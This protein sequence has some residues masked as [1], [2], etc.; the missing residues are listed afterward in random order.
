MFRLIVINNHS[1]NN[2]LSEGACISDIG[3]NCRHACSI[4]HR[5]FARMHLLNEPGMPPRMR[6]RSGFTLGTEFMSD[7]TAD[8][9]TE[10]AAPLK[11]GA[12]SFGSF[13]PKNYV[14]AVF[15]TDAEAGKAG[16]ALR[17]S[18]FSPDDVIVTSGH[19]VVDFDKAAHSEQGLLAK[20]GEKWSR[21]YTDEAADAEAL[22]DLA[23]G[24][25]AFVLA[26]APDD[27]LTARASSVLRPMQ[28]VVLRKYDKMK[29]TELGTEPTP[30]DVA[31]HPQ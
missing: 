17:A 25:Y 27:E 13:F 9:I 16:D 2:L 11:D 18:G 10:S 1:D 30:A 5:A 7:T 6:S 19:D 15:E 29:I 14:L 31:N 3:A 8:Q 22:I 26:Y 20:L 12:Q 28:P 24:G 4:R 21:L 23:R